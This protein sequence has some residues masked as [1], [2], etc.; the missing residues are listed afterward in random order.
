MYALGKIHKRMCAMAQNTFCYADL[1]YVCIRCTVNEKT[2]ARTFTIFKV[3]VKKMC[4]ESASER[5][6]VHGY[7]YKRP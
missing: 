2:L 4:N 1:L 3:R 5:E 6:R 7:T